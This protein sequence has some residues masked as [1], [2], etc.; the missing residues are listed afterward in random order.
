MG[1]FP[2]CKLYA[3]ISVCLSVEDYNVLTLCD[4]VFVYT[5]DRDNGGFEPGQIVAIESPKHITSHM[6]ND[7]N[8][9]ILE[10]PNCILRVKHETIPNFTVP[11]VINS[12]RLHAF[13]SVNA[14]VQITHVTLIDGICKGNFCGG[15]EQMKDGVRTTY[16][17]C[18]TALNG[19]RRMVLLVDMM[20]TLRDVPEEYPSKKLKVFNFTSHK[21]TKYFCKNS[22]IPLG[23]TEGMV[24]QNRKFKHYIMSQV[25]NGVKHVNSCAGWSLAGWVR[26][27]YTK[28]DGIN[29]AAAASGNGVR[30]PPPARI[31][32]SDLTPHVTWIVMNK[33]AGAS[34][35]LSPFKI[36]FTEMLNKRSDNTENPRPQ[37]QRRLEEGSLSSS[38]D[39]AVDASSTAASGD[40]SDL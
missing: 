27:G 8:L 15:L 17:P 37:Q 36:D 1:C 29:N 20:V 39:D 9:P 28:D 11:I 31:I 40:Q 33:K 22:D 5:Q 35:D 16:C 7:N 2:S 34:V 32:N 12:D 25:T 19:K 6:G 21:F 38:K 13:Q 3:C 18:Y 24:N 4:I 14:T 10:V 26:R 23:V 30:P